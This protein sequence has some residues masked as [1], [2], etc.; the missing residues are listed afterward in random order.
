MIQMV[1]MIGI[2]IVFFHLQFTGNLFNLFV[3]GILGAVVFLGLGFAVAGVSK[4]EDQVAPLANMVVFP[5]MV[6]SGIFFSRSN[7]PG[8]VY[9]ITN[10]FPLT[11]LADA[12]RS[13]SIEGSP[14]H[15]VIKQLIGL[16]VWAVF[17]CVL[18]VKMFR[19]E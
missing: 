11:Y 15:G 8:F 16:A 3:V 7:L 18:A 13:I 5:M 19:W 2:G 9:A 14:L 4:S 12:M 6:L 1:L 17:S 10:F